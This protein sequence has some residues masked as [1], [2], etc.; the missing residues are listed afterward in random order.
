MNTEMYRVE[1]A[2]THPQD[3]NV[4]FHDAYIGSCRSRAVAMYWIAYEIQ[5]KL[6]QAALKSEYENEPF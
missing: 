3:F 5:N 1:P 6:T 4:Y 2:D